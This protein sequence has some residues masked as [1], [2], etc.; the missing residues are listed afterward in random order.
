MQ[1]VVWPCDTGYGHIIKVRVHFKNLWL[2]IISC[3]L[4]YTGVE[5]SQNR[6]FHNRRRCF[7]SYKWVTRLYRWFLRWLLTVAGL[8]E[9]WADKTLLH[10]SDWKLSGTASKRIEPQIVDRSVLTCSIQHY[11]A[12]WGRHRFCCCTT[13][14]MESN[15]AVDELSTGKMSSNVDRYERPRDRFTHK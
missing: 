9:V 8:R 15:E 3:C 12:R 13:H 10:L 4:Q 5:P 14:Q 7:T 2:I 11:S 1:Y 6:V